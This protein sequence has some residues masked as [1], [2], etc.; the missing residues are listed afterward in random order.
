MLYEDFKAKDQD[1]GLNLATNADKCIK[2]H[3]SRAGAAPGR[4]GMSDA[5]LSSPTT[6]LE[7][8]HYNGSLLRTHGGCQ[9]TSTCVR[10][11]DE[12]EGSGRRRGGEL[13]EDEEKKG[14]GQ[15]KRVQLPRTRSVVA[16]GFI[17][18]HHVTVLSGAELL[19]TICW[20]A[21]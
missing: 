2:T 14:K 18:R 9:D 11:R 6:L 21:P 15:M 7:T 13:R 8:H 12:T 4:D 17:L 3:A 16:S 5:D 10:S 20:V 19:T 1:H